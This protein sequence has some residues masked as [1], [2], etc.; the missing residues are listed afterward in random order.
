MPSAIVEAHLRPDQDVVPL[1]F[2]VTTERLPPP[3]C[4][5]A[6]IAGFYDAAAETLARHL[7]EGRD[8]A[9]I[10]EGDPFFFGSFMYLHDRLAER[11]M[12]EIVPGVCSIVAVRGRAGHA[13]R[14][15]QPEPCR[16]VGGARRGGAGGAPGRRPTPRR[17]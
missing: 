9:V 5:E 17:S 12:T 8:V 13:A 15:P 6:V 1:V 10:C 14:L 11:Y 2:P 4:Y 7:D 16:A 3:L